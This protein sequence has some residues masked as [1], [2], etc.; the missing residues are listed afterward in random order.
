MFSSTITLFNYEESTDKFYP[1]LFTGTELQP[2]YKT[3]FTE[4]TTQDMDMSLLIIKYYISD[5]K[6]YSY[7]NTKSYKT[8]KSWD[9]LTTANKSNYFT[10]QTGRDFFVLGDYSTTV[11]VD[12]ELFKS[13]NDDVFFINNV[14]VFRDDLKHW[15]ILGY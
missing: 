2:D 9:N 13:Q 10:F 6:I 4:N 7:G 1:T 14:K 15:E 11:N 3:R 8:P 5:N 12:Y